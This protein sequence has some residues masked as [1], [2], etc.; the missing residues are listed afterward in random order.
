MR[1]KH[2]ARLLLIA[3]IPVAGVGLKALG[4]YRSLSADEALIK[5]VKGGDASAVARLLASGAN[6]NAR[7]EDD[8]R[9]PTALMLAARGGRGEIV[10]ALA[11][12][13]AD[14]KAVSDVGTTALMDAAVGG[15]AAVVRELLGRGAGVN[16]VNR[17]G[18]T[19]LIKAAQYGN[20]E[21]A[22]LLVAG[23]ANLGARKH[24][25]LEGARLGTLLGLEDEA[26]P[27][28]AERKHVAEANAF[29]VALANDRSDVA[30]LLLEAGTPPAFLG[31]ESGV[32]AL[33][34]A[35]RKGDLGLV[36]ALIARGVKADGADKSGRNALMEAARFG[37]TE[38]LKG[39]LEKGARAAAADAGGA[40]A[41]H[42]A[43]G[44]GHVPAI[45]ALL[46]AGAAVEG[47]DSLGSTPLM[48]AAEQGRQDAV[49][50]LLAHGAKAATLDK[51][52]RTASQR[53]EDAGNVPVAD[54]L[55]T[56]KSDR[57][58]EGEKLWP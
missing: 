32:A 56:P 8:A 27:S 37:R 5:A 36:R 4:A 23:G 48:L 9:H 16:D 33:K 51:L 44:G 6:P 43:A 45:L 34:L 41:L 19:A 28:A 52:K 57:Q 20:V 25:V 58:P 14:V 26:R 1:R 11:D 24:L 2:L 13:G 46:K 18:D 12:R 35:A 17:Y 29:V 47:A 53:A 50:V 49:K 21:A 55:K 38:V 42:F 3:L 15:D 40:T 10:V 31:D 22:R 39:L 54:S 7:S 30:R